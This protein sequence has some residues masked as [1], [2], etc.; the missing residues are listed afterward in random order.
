[1]LKCADG[2]QRLLFPF[3]HILCGDYEE[4]YVG[5]FASTGVGVV[6]KAAFLGL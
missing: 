1:M 4:Q 2:Q 3:V 5:I 6:L